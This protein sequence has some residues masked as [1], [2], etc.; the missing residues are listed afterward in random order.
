MG[1]CEVV[2]R[3]IFVIPNKRVFCVLERATRRVV[4]VIN[5][6]RLRQWV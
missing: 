3:E 4:W 2:R 6:I 1:A 5:E